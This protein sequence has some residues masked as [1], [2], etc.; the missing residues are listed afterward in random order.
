MDGPSSPEE[1]ETS[2]KLRTWQELEGFASK[3]G[4]VENPLSVGDI[5]HEKGWGWEITDQ[6]RGEDPLFKIV[7]LEKQGDS[8]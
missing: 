7:E 5:L 6:K 2:G 3:Y 1:Q 4:I 8:Q